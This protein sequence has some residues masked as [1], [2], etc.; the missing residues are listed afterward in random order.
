MR[1][2]IFVN[3]PAHA[4]TYRNFVRQATE[5]GDDVLVLAREYSCTLD[6]L[7]YHDIDYVTYGTHDT[8]RY[9]LANFAMELPEQFARIAWH[10]RRFS[11]E[12]IFGRGPY[13]GFAGSVCEARVV[14]LLDS[15]PSELLHQI[16]SRVADLIITPSVTDID[17]GA[18]HYR[19]EGFKECGYLHPET[20]VPDYSVR[21]ELGV[22]PDVPLVI[23]R[24]DSLDALHD[25]GEAGHSA[26]YRQRLIEQLSEKAR[27]LVSDEG[28]TVDLSDLDGTHFE[29]HP[30]RMHDALATADLLVA[31]TGTMVTES[32]FLG[33]P[34][35]ACGGFVEQE[36]GE[37]VALEEA[38]LIETATDIDEVLGLS[39]AVLDDKDASARYQQRRLA[40]TKELVDLTE[41]L[42]TVSRDVAWTATC[43]DPSL[44]RSR[45]SP[46]DTPTQ[47]K[48]SYNDNTD[49]RPVVQ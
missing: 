6:I 33:T 48:S 22:E 27:V 45:G 39:L 35:I 18:N 7:E 13:A 34:A 43:G 31:E 26:N 42:H 3:T 1:L 30:A 47:R 20:Y 25:R 38:G 19:I 16:S 21:E 8:S 36:F 49:T 40:F 28:G 46:E 41:L 17:L 15:E 2:A 24:F 29:L 10:I 5:S 44:S 23:V 32:A 14:L 9:S 11:P 37:F 4:H 12:I